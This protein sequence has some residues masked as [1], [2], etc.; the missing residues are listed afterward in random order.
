MCYLCYYHNH[1]LFFSA[2]S[3]QYLETGFDG[4][5]TNVGKIAIGWYNG[6]YAYGGWTNLNM[7]AGEI[8]NPKRYM[9]SHFVNASVVSNS[10]VN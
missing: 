9:N 3:T 1:F 10:H 5:E 7:V 4:T 2:G 8:K 6:M